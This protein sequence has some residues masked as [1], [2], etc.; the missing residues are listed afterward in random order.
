VVDP[1]N[2]GAGLFEED[3]GEAQVPFLNSK[4]EIM[5]SE[6]RYGSR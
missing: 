1:V 4:Q 5:I 6:E 2:V 3:G